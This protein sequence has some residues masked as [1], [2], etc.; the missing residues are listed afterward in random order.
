MYDWVLNT[1]LIWMYLVILRRIFSLHIPEYPLCHGLSKN[2]VAQTFNLYCTVCSTRET[3][4]IFLG[5]Q[6]NKI[7]EDCAQASSEVD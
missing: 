6:T 4:S 5:I 2:H 3:R 7:K 1:P